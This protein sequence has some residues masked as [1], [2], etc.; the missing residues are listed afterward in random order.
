M[1]VDLESAERMAAWLEEEIIRQEFKESLGLTGNA[2]NAESPALPE[3]IP[4]IP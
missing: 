3:S 2:V 4:D 1:G